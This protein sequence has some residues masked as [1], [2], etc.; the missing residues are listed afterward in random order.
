MLLP[1]TNIE[2]YKMN[3]VSNHKYDNQAEIRIQEFYLELEQLRKNKRLVTTSE[4]LEAARAGN[5]CSYR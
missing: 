4:E 3:H 1:T 5:S 2:E